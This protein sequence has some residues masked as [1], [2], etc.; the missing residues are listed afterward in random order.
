VPNV[1]HCRKWH[2]S[3]GQVSRI[4]SDKTLDSIDLSRVAR[5]FTP[6]RLGGPPDGQKAISQS[7]TLE[8]I[9]PHASRFTLHVSRFTFHAS[10]F[11]FHASRFTFHVS[12]RSALPLTRAIGLNEHMKPILA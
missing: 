8:A 11:T 7:R 10:R 6:L 2:G 5:R 12:R 9:Y 1:K 4:E 3:S